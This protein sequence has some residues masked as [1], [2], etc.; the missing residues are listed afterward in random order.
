PL[1]K[2]LKATA[3]RNQC[4][5]RL[6]DSPAATTLV[7][8][9]WFFRFQRI[10]FL[11]TQA[12]EKPAVASVP[13]GPEAALV[14]DDVA[15][16]QGAMMDRYATLGIPLTFAILPRER[17]SREL[18]EKATALHFPVILH[19]PMQPIDLAHN[20]PGG[21]GLYLKMTP[22]QLH[23]QF[24]K[25]VASVPDIVG[26]NNHMGSAFTEDADKMSLV[27][28]WV[29]EQNLFFLDSR[30]SMHSIVPKVAKK[31]GVPC[32]V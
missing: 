7:L 3:R 15:Y 23:E 6:Y 9:R 18:A 22:Q 30:T 19:L 2:S 26:I 17:H 31:I 4:A 5:W 21:A 20:D 12:A 29:K 11:K 32:H 25:D 14:I 1:L 16:D 24:E 10:A 27:L 28:R 8:S 13:A